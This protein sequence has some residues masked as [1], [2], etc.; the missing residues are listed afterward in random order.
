KVLSIGGTLRLWSEG[1]MRTSTRN[2][3][4]ASGD[5]GGCERKRSRSYAT[6]T[7]ALSQ[8]EREVS[9]FQAV[10]DSAS[11]SPRSSAARARSKALSRSSSSSV[12]ATRQ[13]SSAWRS[14]LA[15]SEATSCTPRWSAALL[16][17][18]ALSFSCTASRC[19]A[20]WWIVAVRTG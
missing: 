3:Y 7:P 2:D 13:P 15:Q 20:P 8:R 1:D 10:L 16:S 19:E 17:S 4:V 12:A 9:K 18:C 6:L 14:T 11:G 5:S